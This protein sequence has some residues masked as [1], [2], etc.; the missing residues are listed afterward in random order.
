MIQIKKTNGSKPRPQATFTIGKTWTRTS[1][2][3]KTLYI[4]DVHFGQP[5]VNGLGSR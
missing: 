1:P 3:N 2:I 5:P 4:G